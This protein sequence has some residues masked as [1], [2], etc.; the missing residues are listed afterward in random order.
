MKQI[1][2][3]LKC[4]SH[5]C[6]FIFKFPIIKRERER[7]RSHQQNVQ[8]RIYLQIWRCHNSSVGSEIVLV[9]TFLWEGAGASS[10]KKIHALKYNKFNNQKII[11][12]G[13]LIFYACSWW[14]NVRYECLCWPKSKACLILDPMDILER[15]Q[16][17]LYK[18]IT[19]EFWA[20]IIWGSPNTF[21]DLILHFVG[22]IFRKWPKPI[23]L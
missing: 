11:K 3:F 6:W 19:G 14:Y 22:Q 12:Q 2:H 1:I 21:E 15:L 17:F 10:R 20:F 13:K 4:S 18:V 23:A 16:E 7:E 5:C 8:M 9:F